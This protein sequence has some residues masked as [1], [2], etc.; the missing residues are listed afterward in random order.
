MRHIATHDQEALSNGIKET[1]YFYVL[2]CLWE[3][4]PNDSICLE[5]MFT[6]G[7]CEEIRLAEQWRLDYVPR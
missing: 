3:G 4:Q 5:R 1:E 2:A 7:G 6:K